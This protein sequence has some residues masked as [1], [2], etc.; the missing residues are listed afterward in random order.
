[1][2]DYKSIITVNQQRPV[3]NRARGRARALVR[4]KGFSRLRSLY[5]LLLSNGI[6]VRLF[7]EDF[8]LHHYSCDSKVQRAFVGWGWK[9]QWESPGGNVNTPSLFVI[10]KAATPINERGNKRENYKWQPAQLCTSTVLDTGAWLARLKGL[11]WIAVGDNASHW[12][13]MKWK[14]REDS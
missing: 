6:E 5:M 3:I 2:L 11:L 10:Y 7:H 4:K 1:M 9:E 12:E 13:P 14:K 8:Y